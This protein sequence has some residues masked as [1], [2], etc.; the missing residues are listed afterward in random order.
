MGPKIAVNSLKREKY[1]TKKNEIAKYEIFCKIFKNAPIS[2]RKRVFPF[3]IWSF[4]TKILE[5]PNLKP[6][7]RKNPK[8][9][10]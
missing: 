1:E 4:L 3:Q 6:I 2:Q 10:Y 7:F 9:K 8:G 5:E